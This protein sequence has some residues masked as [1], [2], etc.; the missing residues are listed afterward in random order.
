MRWMRRQL[1]GDASRFQG[2]VELFR[3]IL[4]HLRGRGFLSKGSVR[5]ASKV[6]E[7]IDPRTAYL[8]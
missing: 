1:E 8:A 7:I 5:A 4:N 3:M 2:E 6:K